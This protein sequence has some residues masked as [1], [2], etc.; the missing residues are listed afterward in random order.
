LADVTPVADN[1]A[2]HSV[3]ARFLAHALHDESIVAVLTFAVLV[4]KQHNRDDLA[5]FALDDVFLLQFLG[6]D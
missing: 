3:L 6:F 5:A 2:A 4:L 1:R